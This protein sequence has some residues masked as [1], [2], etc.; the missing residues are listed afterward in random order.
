MTIVDGRAAARLPFLSRVRRPVS[1]A[2]LRR[3]V[4][5]TVALPGEPGYAA[6]APWNRAAD[7]R[8][9]AVV[10]VTGPD[11]VVEVVRF[12]RRQGWT[13]AVQR[14]GHAGV[15]V[16]ER[17]VL[18]LT[19]GLGTVTV[20]PALGSA[21]VGA[22]VVWDE[23]LAASSPHGLAPLCGSAPGVGVA[24]MLTGGGLGPVARTYGVSSDRVTA[25]EVVTGRGELRRAT[26]TENADLFWG[27][28]GGKATLGV[29]TAV[30]FD[31]VAQPELFGGCVWFDGA[32]APV[33]LEAWRRMAE[34]LP[35]AGTT[36]VALVRLP[37][38][39]GVPE[40]LAGR[41]TVAVRYAWTGD[42]AS[43]AAHLAPVLAA[44]T[45]VLGGVARMP[46]TA[47]GAIHADP[48]DPMPSLEHHTLLH[49]LPAD[50]VTALLDVAGPGSDC[51]QTVVE[52]R[53][54]GG[55]VARTPQVPS[56]YCHRDAAYSLL[57]VG[58]PV[59]PA[60]AA[61]PADGARVVAALGPW[62]T[63]G[64]L[65]NFGAATDP[66]RLERTYDPE[67]RRRLAALA[68]QHDPSGVFR[69]GLAVR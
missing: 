38:M 8:P 29:V 24:G 58:V 65:P 66:Q 9:A 21:R 19:E 45:P 52:L 5:G 22:G 6:A 64:M 69:T 68:Q 42:D 30:E 59:G 1:P 56:A 53:R 67:T 26:A 13:V 27:L 7:V 12:A 49:G 28:R 37:P 47:I 11:D 18:V 54:L 57:A 31:L 63:G 4:R 48:V 50:A 10:A 51:L 34:D 16:G 62:S 39:P 35:E 2:G 14:T 32:D 41:T 40:P 15:P 55:A 60:T 3:R 43:G 46:Y 61:V 17:T 23:V 25:I 20:D 44:A 36:S 33:V